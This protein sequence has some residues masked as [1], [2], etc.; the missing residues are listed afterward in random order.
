M[1]QAEDFIDKD[2]LRNWILQC[3]ETDDGGFADRPENCADVFHTFFALAALSMM[4]K[5]G[6]EEIDCHMAVLKSSLVTI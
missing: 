1:I 5:D 4:G 2:L 6:L 3:Q